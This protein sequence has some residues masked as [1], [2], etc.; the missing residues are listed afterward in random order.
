MVLKFGDKVMVNSGARYGLER[1]EVIQTK[2]GFVYV[3]VLRFI[4]G[5]MNTCG[6]WYQDSEVNPA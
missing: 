5:G 4:Y 2:P 1:G 3:N 6:G